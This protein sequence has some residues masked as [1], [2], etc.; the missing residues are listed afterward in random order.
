VNRH[1]GGVRAGHL[2]G[3]GSFNFV[4]WRCGFDYSESGINVGF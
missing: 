4:F 1:G 2:D 3:E